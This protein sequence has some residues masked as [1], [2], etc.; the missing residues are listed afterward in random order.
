MRPVAERATGQRAGP[1]AAAVFAT[2]PGSD[3]TGSPPAGG[4]ADA[5]GG[6]TGPF[7]VSPADAASGPSAGRTAPVGA[8]AGGSST[9]P[10]T[11]GL[12]AP[13]VALPERVPDPDRSARSLQAEP[14]VL[15]L[16]LIAG[17]A[18]VAWL[19]SRAPSV[20]VVAVAL[21]IVVVVDAVIAVRALGDVS[22][23]VDNPP[24]A[25]A[26]YP[27]DL[28]L[29]L[30]RTRRPVEAQLVGA[31]GS[32]PVLVSR[33]PGVLTVPAPRRGVVD[34]IVFDLRARGPFGLWTA[35]R[36]LRIWLPRPLHV[37]PLPAAHVLDWPL[38]RATD[39]G[40][41]PVARTGEDLFRGVRPYVRGDARRW[42]HWP[43]TAQHGEL[44][45]KEHEG[46]GTV[47]IELVADLPVP[48][49]HTE[50]ALGRV[51]WLALSC[52]H[53]G[54]RVRLVTVEP[55]PPPPPPA[56]TKAGAGVAAPPPPPLVGTTVVRPVSTATELARRLALA[57]YGAPVHTP[58]GGF[59]RIVSPGGDRWA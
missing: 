13:T 37:G 4:P 45:V 16:G 38:P 44:M 8:G 54:W 27:F 42:V 23:E 32:P 20:L 15:A 31:R 55:P 36:R 7:A 29:A 28:V 26:G 58:F 41:S 11:L 5:A 10:P 59:T 21:T 48:G 53:Q 47:T 9:L 52:L 49:P 35:G 56:L 46:T 43:A 24:E 30:T 39:V 40:L 6:P 12:A 51:A 25:V 3:L 17:V 57:G 19:I 1:D 2:P 33:E 14:I 34:H 50:L 22:A 18:G